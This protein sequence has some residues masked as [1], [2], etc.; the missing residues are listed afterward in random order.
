MNKKIIISGIIGLVLGFFIAPS[1]PSISRNSMTGVDHA[2]IS[3]IDA[4]FIEEMI[5][6]H[7]D[8]ISMANLALGKSEH[9]EIRNLANNIIKSQSE[10]ISR[11]K[12][13]Y[14]AWYGLLVPGPSRSAGHGMG[15]MTHG[16]MM[17]DET[18]LELLKNA[19]PFD[20]EFIEEMIPHHQMAVMMAQMLLRSTTRPEMKNLAEDIISAQTREIDEMRGWHRAWYGTRAR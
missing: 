14:E 4:K 20:K 11:M 1:F 7:E 19:I 15:M 12:E 10:E 8:A 13:W 5:P 18:D 17:G 9:P 2:G 3:G 16:G 6:H